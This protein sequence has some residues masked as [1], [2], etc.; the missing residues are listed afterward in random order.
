M[1]CPV[2]D[3]E[4]QTHDGEENKRVSIRWNLTARIVETEKT[5]GGGKRTTT[6][7]HHTTGQ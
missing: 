5:A 7:A 4:K 3:K 1:I 6:Q 2:Q